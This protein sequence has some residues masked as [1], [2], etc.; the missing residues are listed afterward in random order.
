MQCYLQ[1]QMQTIFYKFALLNMIQIII[2][3]V[4]FG[5]LAM[6]KDGILAVMSM[7]IGMAYADNPDAREPIKAR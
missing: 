1:K 5:K 6:N 4:S 2:I 7:A 3:S